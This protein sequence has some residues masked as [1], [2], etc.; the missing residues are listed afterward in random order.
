MGIGQDN[1]KEGSK[2]EH[3]GKQSKDFKLVGWSQR[4]STEKSGKSG[5]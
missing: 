4:Y 1:R 5:N 3:D 2:L